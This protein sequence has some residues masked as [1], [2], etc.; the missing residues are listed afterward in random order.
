MLS[1]QGSSSHGAGAGR[2]SS[3]R[4]QTPLQPAPRAPPP[5]PPGAWGCLAASPCG[6]WR[7][8]R[9]MCTAVLLCAP[10]PTHTFDLGARTCLGT[11]WSCLYS[12]FLLQLRTQRL[13]HLCLLLAPLQ[14]WNR[15]CQ[16]GNPTAPSTQPRC[17]MQHGA[18]PG[19]RT[20]S[21]SSGCLPADEEAAVFEQSFDGCWQELCTCGGAM[22]CRDPRD[23]WPGVVRGRS[24][25]DKSSREH[26]F[27]LLDFFDV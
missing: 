6:S 16:Q 10:P 4:P 24:S 9:A 14:G 20:P 21:S 17:L 7:R 15:P 22:H 8:G 13:L 25:G 26:F 23:I 2:G 5:Y 11:G 27:H 19:L 3:L 1:A 12:A 18:N